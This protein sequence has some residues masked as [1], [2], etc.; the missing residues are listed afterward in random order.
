MKRPRGRRHRPAVDVCLDH[1]DH[2]APRLR[3][4]QGK[5]LVPTFTAYAVT[6]LLKEHFGALV[7]LGFTGQIEEDLDEISKGERRA[8]SSW[9]RST[10]AAAAVNGPA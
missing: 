4:A 8:T 5:A 6:H 2:R 10:T 1:L 3:L 7:E 9:R